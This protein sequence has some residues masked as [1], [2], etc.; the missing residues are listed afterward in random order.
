MTVTSSPFSTQAPDPARDDVRLKPVAIV[1]ADHLR[2]F[3]GQDLGRPHQ[4]G[5]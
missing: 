3:A 4:P 1:D 5:I 2:K